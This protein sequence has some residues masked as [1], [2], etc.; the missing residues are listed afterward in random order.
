MSVRIMLGDID[1]GDP[2]NFYAPPHPDTQEEMAEQ[3]DPFMQFC[4]ESDPLNNGLTFRQSLHVP[5]GW[6]EPE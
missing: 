5:I 1:C 4:E 6:G 3:Y 2:H